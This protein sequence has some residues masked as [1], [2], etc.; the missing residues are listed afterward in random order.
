MVIVMIHV[1]EFHQ[2]QNQESLYQLSLEHQKALIDFALPFALFRDYEAR[3]KTCFSV[4][5]RGVFHTDLRFSLEGN[6]PYE[7][8]FISRI[9]QCRK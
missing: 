4:E 6:S 8:K 5:L 9:S 1:Q 7:R 3:K 2:S